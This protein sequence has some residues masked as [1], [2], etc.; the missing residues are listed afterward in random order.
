[1]VGTAKRSGKSR[2]FINIGNHSKFPR[3]E[4]ESVYLPK[5]KSIFLS[6]YYYSTQQDSK[7]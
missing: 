6:I 7:D 3:V 5:Q 1:M 2:G 4:S